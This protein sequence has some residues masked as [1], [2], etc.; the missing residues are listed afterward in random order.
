MACNKLGFELK[1]CSRCGGSGRYS[2]N[3]M[4]GDRCYGCGGTGVVLSKRGA[5]ARAKF[6]EL[7][8]RPVASIKPGDLVYISGAAV[9][10]GKA[11]REV[12]S[13]KPDSLNAGHICV[14]FK[15]FTYNLSVNS[16]DMEIVNNA[17][18]HAAK[19]AVA[20][21]YQTTLADNGKPKGPRVLA[22]EAKAAAETAAAL[23]AEDAA[24]MAAADYYYAY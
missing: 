13:V 5:A 2:Y 18:D 1:T 17:A 10:S 16:P 24:V 7:C 11:F 19:L 23:A 15:K 4:D 6:F 22:R 20:I 21:T 8:L 3:M 9:L 14:E 12:L